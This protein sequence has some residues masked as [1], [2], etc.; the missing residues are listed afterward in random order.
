[1][2]KEKTYASEEMNPKMYKWK[3]IQADEMEDAY[4]IGPA[5]DFA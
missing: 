1:M 3:Q 4:R 5:F 2:R